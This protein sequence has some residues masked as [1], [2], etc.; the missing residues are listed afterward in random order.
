MN[1]RRK[2]PIS[3]TGLQP[4][5]AAFIDTLSDELAEV[6]MLDEQYPVRIVDKPPTTSRFFSAACLRGV[7]AGEQIRFYWYC[8]EKWYP[9]WVRKTYL[10]E[11]AHAVALNTEVDWCVNGG[12][13]LPFAIL[14]AT[15]LRRS[16]DALPPERRPGW[17]EVMVLSVYDV[18]SEPRSTWGHAIQTALD[19][20]SK[21]AR[22]ALS[23]E[24]CSELLWQ[25]WHNCKKQFA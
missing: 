13:T 3:W 2:I 12:H 22:Q 21:L 10:H 4:P 14:Y 16:N 20:S 7:P 6:L 17:D 23:I 9:S 24:R 15:L 1:E 8:S 25:D 18:S 19:V 11:L 5:P